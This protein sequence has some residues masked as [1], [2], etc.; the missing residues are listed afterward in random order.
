MKEVQIMTRKLL[1]AILAAAAAM[2]VCTACGA[3]DKKGG[4]ADGTSSAADAAS[5]DAA[6]DASR[7]GSAENNA[8]ET[9]EPTVAKSG[10]AILIITDGQWYA[11]YFGTAEDLLSYGAGAVQITGNGDYTVSVNAGSAGT[12]KEI[13]GDP[14]GSYQCSGLGFAAVKVMDGTKLFPEM[15]IEIRE[16]RVDGNP[17]QLSAKNYT[18]SDDNTEMRANIYN[19]YVSRFPDDAHNADGKLTGEFGEYSS[20]IVDP[21]AFSKWQKVEVDFTVSGIGAQE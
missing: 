3:K 13:T 16:I 11:K 5:G 1:A 10:D 17:V 14:N 6:G 20:Q 15:S 21:A 18:S 8:A 9:E 12:Q 7:N 4:N 2:T 19:E